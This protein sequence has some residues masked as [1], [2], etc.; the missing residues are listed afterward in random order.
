MSKNI[1]RIVI[2]AAAV[3]VLALAFV[4][5]K[6]VFPEKEIIIEETPEPTESPV[7]Y[8]LRRSGDEVS[9]KDAQGEEHTVEKEFTFNI[10]PAPIWDDPGYEEPVVPEKTGLPLWAKG[11]IAAAVLVGAVFGIKAVKKHK[12]AKAEALDLDE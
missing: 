12:K 2:A 4:L 7:V 5:L 1:R 8:L 10:Q 9:L 11:L 3:V 6:Y